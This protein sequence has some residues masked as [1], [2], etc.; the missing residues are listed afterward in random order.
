MWKAKERVWRYEGLEQE[1][2]I[3]RACKWANE[4]NKRWGWKLFRIYL[5]TYWGLRLTYPID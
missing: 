2:L 3:I 5:I 4:P 1:G